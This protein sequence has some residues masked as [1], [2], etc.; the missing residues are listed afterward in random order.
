MPRIFSLL[1]LLLIQLP[2]HAG[3]WPQWLGPRRDGSTDEKIAPWKQD[4]KPLWTQPVSEGHSSPVVAKGRVFLHTA[5]GKDK[6][7]ET[8][9][10]F[11]AVSGKPVWSKTYE[12]SNFKSKFGNGPRATPAVVDGKV[13]TFGISGLLT[14]FDADK[15]DQLWQLDML[16]ELKAANLLFGVSCSP[17]IVGDRILVNVG[18]KDTSIVAVDKNN[19]KI[20][21]HK[22]DDKASYSSGIVVKRAGVEQAIF[23]TA[24]GVVSLSPEDGKVF[25]QQPLVDLLFESS[26]TPVLVGDMLFASSVT[27]GGMGIKL[28]DTPAGP[29]AKKEW[30][31]TKLNCYFSTPVAVGTEYLYM[32]TPSSLLAK[33]KTSSLRCIEI[34][35]GKEMWNR[36]NVG[37]YHASLLRT[38]DDKMLLLE[39]FGQLV[40]FDP[41]PK[42]FKELARSKIC[43]NTWAHPALSDGKFYIRDATSLICVALN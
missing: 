8:L 1:L 11:D 29:S 35:T 15:G 22:L 24:K 21:W 26:T 42:E 43:G 39:E 9:T 38:G 41:N 18:G 28:L 17:L 12:R 14:C 2:L 3:D 10:A 16:K 31:N 34:A 23:L 7:E 20:L 30:T 25:W 37:E 27:F 40:L 5:G 33:K 13:Y 32:V 6:F 4:L 36:P 19:G